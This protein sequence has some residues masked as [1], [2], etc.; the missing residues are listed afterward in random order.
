MEP[1]GSRHTTTTDAYQ[2]TP[3]TPAYDDGDSA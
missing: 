3:E 1:S 2:A